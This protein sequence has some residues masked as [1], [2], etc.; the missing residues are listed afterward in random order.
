[1]IIK[2]DLDQSPFRVE[3]IDHPEVEFEAISL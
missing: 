2:F 3:T 1:M